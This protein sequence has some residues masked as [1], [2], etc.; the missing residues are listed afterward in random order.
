MWIDERAKKAINKFYEYKSSYEQERQDKIDKIHKKYTGNDGEIQKQ[1]SKIKQSCIYCKRN[2]NTK[3]IK[4][5]TKLIIMCGDI[6]IP[7][8]DKLEIIIPHFIHINDAIQE[9][10][11]ALEELRKNIIKV[12]ADLTYEFIDEEH[13]INEFQRLNDEF[14]GDSEFY[15]GLLLYKGNIEENNERAHMMISKLGEINKLKQYSYQILKKY[16]KTNTQ[17]LLQ[18]YIELIK[19]KVFP[20]KQQ[21]QNL[22]YSFQEMT[23]RNINSGEEGAGTIEYNLFQRH[24]LFELYQHIWD[25]EDSNVLQNGKKNDSANHVI[26]E[27]SE[28]TK[29]NQNNEED[30]DEDNEED[31]NEQNDNNFNKNGINSENNNN[32][33]LEEVDIGEGNIAPQNEVIELRPK[34]NEYETDSDEDED[35]DEDET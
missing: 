20:Q 10:N 24:N 4:K 35:E 19:C 12:R 23:S 9:Y 7:C 32:E 5:D 30:N 28:E 14:N 22:R 18:D 31:N 25:V 34:T 27:D 16:A 13:A 3:F 21:L 6:D 29:R 2:V 33:D 26:V 11:K 17:Q 1:I 8:P 15:T